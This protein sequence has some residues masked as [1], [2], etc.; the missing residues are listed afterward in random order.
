MAEQDNQPQ[1]SI[2]ATPQSSLDDSTFAFN[3]TILPQPIM[4]HTPSQFT[5]PTNGVSS[6]QQQQGGNSI[7]QHQPNPQ[8][9]PAHSSH[10][11]N[12][13][14]QQQQ[15]SNSQQNNLQQNAQ[16]TTHQVTNPQQQNLLSQ[17]SQPHSNQR[18]Q[19]QRQNA[20][21]PQSQQVYPSQTQTHQQ[22]LPVQQIPVQYP[23]YSVPP[24]YFQ[25]SAPIVKTNMPPLQK[26]NIEGWFLSLD[27]WFRANNIVSDEQR[28]LN[29]MTN[30]EPTV[31]QQIVL[32]CTNMP[33]NNQ[34]E[35]VK[36]LIIQYYADS[37][38]SRLNKVLNEMPLG[39]LKPSQLF[40]RMTQTAGD[41][42]SQTA[43]REI[44]ESRLQF[45][46]ER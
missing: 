43:I 42:M 4:P 18:V 29:V 16:Q 7:P 39:D 13:Q 14:Q 45:M 32:Q 10:Q 20:Q 9:Q 17:F 33:R 46:L 21:Q 38:K 30:L 5:E 19:I 44:W 36:K 23:S 41:T 1:K 24:S 8:E 3:S 27:F 15:H 25:P 12:L 40:Q 22:Q 28:Y 26:N 2:F 35:F 11:S 6:N 37:K 31:L 34:Y